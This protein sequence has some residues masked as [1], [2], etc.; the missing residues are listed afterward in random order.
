MALPP[1]PPVPP[2]A[3]LDAFGARGRPE[4]LPGGQGTSV[5]VGDLVFKPT[6]AGP[7]E[8]EWFAALHERLA[9]HPGFRVPAPARAPDGR[10]LV[11]GWTAAAHLPGEP[12]PRGRWAEVIRAGR[13]LHE[14][15]R[16][17]PAPA[18]LA[19]RTDPWA[20]ADRV[21]WGEIE[22]GVR[23]E[24]AA[25]FARL[26]ATG[27]GEPGRPPTTPSQ[28]VHGDLTGNVLFTP[29]RPPTVIDLS[30]YW[31]P[32]AF[33]EAVVA[34][35]GL[36]WHGLPHPPPDPDGQEPPDRAYFLLR[37]LLFRLVAL[38][39]G[40]DPGPLPPGEAERLDRV[41]RLL[42]GAPGRR[43]ATGPPTARPDR[44]GS[45]SRP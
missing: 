2:A 7:A 29:G 35:D 12:G 21:A 8:A 25:S 19:A 38:D 42:T 22:H 44:A 11:A 24:L 31:R 41:T 27:A 39:A 15:L 43:P 16:E 26:R 10:A 32:P 13:A 6:A 17:E 18:F 34:V 33:A 28:L 23:P 36:L 9:G 1:P 37:A 20:L 40:H 3:V 30:P 5:R 4:P 45:D 14:A